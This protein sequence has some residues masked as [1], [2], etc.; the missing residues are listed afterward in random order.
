MPIL[1]EKNAGKTSKLSFS[2]FFLANL[3]KNQKLKKILK[4]KYSRFVAY[5]KVVEKNWYIR[6]FNSTI[7]FY[8]K[9]YQISK[10]QN[11]IIFEQGWILKFCK[12]HWLPWK[13]IFHISL[14]LFFWP[15]TPLSPQ[16]FSEIRVKI[17]ELSAFRP[18]YKLSIFRHFEAIFRAKVV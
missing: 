10:P 3:A 14:T 16:M 11:E 9:P 18:F 4:K 7:L 5:A 12:K 2:L 8:K 1:N 13:E 15:W 6:K 17:K